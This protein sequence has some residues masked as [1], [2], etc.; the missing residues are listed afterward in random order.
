MIRSLSTA[1]QAWTRQRLVTVRSH[2]CQRSLVWLRPPSSVHTSFNVSCSNMKE[3]LPQRRP[4][5]QLTYVP[6]HNNTLLFLVHVQGV[7]HGALLGGVAVWRAGRCSFTICL[8]QSRTRHVTKEVKVALKQW[9]QSSG[10]VL[11]GKVIFPCLVWAVSATCWPVTAGRTHRP[12]SGNI[13]LE[14]IRRILTGSQC[15]DLTAGLL[16]SSNSL[17]H[18][19]SEEVSAVVHPTRYKSMNELL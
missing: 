6:I 4:L 12:G 9:I 8:R 18:E 17:I 10:L 11:R 13:N 16:S 1:L 3:L 15:K 7:Q 5:L 2:L 19:A 14:T